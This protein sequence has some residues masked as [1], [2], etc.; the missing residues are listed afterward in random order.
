[1]EAGGSCWRQ[2]AAE[3]LTLRGCSARATGGAEE[4][5]PILRVWDGK[6]VTRIRRTGC[7]DCVRAVIEN[8]ELRSEVQEVATAKADGLRTPFAL[9]RR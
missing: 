2:C 6:H 4:G 9:R 7:M 5:I 1:M 3:G 8:E